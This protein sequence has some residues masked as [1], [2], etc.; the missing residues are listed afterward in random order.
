MTAQSEPTSPVTR[1]T[2]R[3]AVGEHKLAACDD[4]VFLGLGGPVGREF[5]L[6]VASGRA[7]R[8]GKED[9]YVLAGK[10]DADTHVAFP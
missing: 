6:D 8:R 9:F 2:V 3:I 5:R 7:L 4:P 1:I 10:D